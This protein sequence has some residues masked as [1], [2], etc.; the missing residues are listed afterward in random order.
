MKISEKT[1]TRKALFESIRQK[2]DARELSVVT[3]LPAIHQRGNLQKKGFRKS[4]D[5]ETGR[6]RGLTREDRQWREAVLRRDGYACVSCTSTEQLEVDHIKPF[7]LYPE[8]RFHVEN[9][10]T[11]CHSCHAKT[12]T[13]GRKVHSLAS[14]EVETI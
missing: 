14:V 1:A 13:Y 10:Q 2:R 4:I 6:L 8:F 3:K 12:A 5:A 11:L 9:G 7:C